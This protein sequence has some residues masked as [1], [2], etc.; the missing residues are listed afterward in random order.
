MNELIDSHFKVDVIAATPSPQTACYIDAH[1]CYSEDNAFE[2]CT[3]NRTDLIYWH[4][5]FKPENFL[6]E[7]EAGQRV[8]RNCLKYKHFGVIESPSIHFHVGGFPHSVLGQARTHRV[9]ITFNVQSGRYTGQR[10]VKLAKEISRPNNSADLQALAESI[11]YLRPV[12]AY[13]DRFAKSYE[14][15]E[16]RRQE[17]LHIIYKAAEQYASD[18]EDGL[19]EEHARSLLPFELRQNFTV[20]FNIR[21]LFHFLDMRTPKDA[22]LEIRKLCDMIWPYVEEWVPDFA[23]YYYNTRWSKN[24]LAP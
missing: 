11:F 21:S 9:G 20:A 15:T 13:T 23:E 17:H 4:D 2:E 18:L 8:I 14:Y 10:V 22:Q 6:S 24:Q 5:P 1:T 3:A 7:K 12:G 19:S 16:V